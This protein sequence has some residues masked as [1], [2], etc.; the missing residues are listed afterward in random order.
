MAVMILN[1]RT[2]TDRQYNYTYHKWVS[3]FDAQIKES[4]VVP[5][6]GD[7]AGV[8]CYIVGVV[9]GFILL[10]LSMIRRRFPNDRHMRRPYAHDPQ[11]LHFGWHWKIQWLVLVIIVCIYSSVIS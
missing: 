4:I 11:I 7:G 2:T 8:D 10:Y 3:S 6:G 1:A 5:C 9:F